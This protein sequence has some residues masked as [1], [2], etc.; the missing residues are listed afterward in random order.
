MAIPAWRMTMKRRVIVV[1]IVLALWVAAIVG[2]LVFLQVFNHGEF[3]KLAERQQNRTQDAPAKR[4]DIFDRRGR[5]LATSVDADSVYAVPN[6]LGDPV[7]V[8]ARLCRALGDC[9][10]KEQRQIG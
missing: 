6:E 3:V 9:D 2:R 1:A 4:G 7:A 5:L 8:A 10:R